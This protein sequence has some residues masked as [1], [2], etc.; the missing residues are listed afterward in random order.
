LTPRRERLLVLTQLY[1]PEPNFI[2][3]DV[4]EALAESMD[5][6]VIT[7]HPNY[8]LGRFYSGTKWWRPTRTHEN[9]V[10]VW[11]LPMY[12]DHTLSTLRRALSFI[13][14]AFMATLIAPFVA[15]RPKAVWVYHGIFTTALAAL[16]FKLA[17]GSRLIIT[18]ADLWPESFEAAG[19][20]K[21]QSILRAMFAYRRFINRRADRLIC[22]TRGTLQ[23]FAREGI[24][25]NRLSYV[26]VWV[27]G[28]SEAVSSASA[29]ATLNIVYV[30]NIGA[31][32]K[33]DT[34]IRAAVE[35]DREGERVTVHLYGGGT[36]QPE[37][38]LLATSLQATNVTFH[39]RISPAEAF[40]VSSTAFAQYVAL[41]PSPL[42]RMTVPSKLAFSFAAGAPV[43]VGLE[44]E[45]A[46]LAQE[47]GGAFAFDPEN[48]GSLA[49]AIR[50]VL[51]L[52]RTERDALAHR[53]RAFYHQN[54]AKSSLLRNYVRELA[55][56]NR[57]I[58]L[59][60]MD[61]RQPV[62]DA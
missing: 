30:G 50:R 3:A 10:T 17:Y 4:A 11:R 52:T 28:I 12:P 62:N 33:L 47:S 34:L 60:G 5:V 45:S 13:S 39:G 27:D 35:L 29:L 26:P 9:G 51:A 25:V 23:A 57:R 8:P 18:W 20:S 19:V 21:R 42:F 6:V 44:G 43:L 15:G 37:L 48:V 53:L 38:E 31:A 41:Q 36:A 46:E 61:L 16:W 55:Y 49:T 22:S 58:T 54:F 24:P 14:F 40:Q 1:R 59:P 2:T 32:Q 56:E 7:A